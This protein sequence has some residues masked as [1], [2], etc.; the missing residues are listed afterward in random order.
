LY[1]TVFVCKNTIQI[2]LNAKFGDVNDYLYNFEKF[3]N[4]SGTALF[5]QSFNN[6]LQ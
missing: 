4:K 2:F 6:N 1:F 3:H 5:N